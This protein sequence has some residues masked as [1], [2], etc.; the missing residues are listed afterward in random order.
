MMKRILLALVVIIVPL[1]ALAQPDPQNP[2]GDNLTTPSTWKVRL[3]RPNA[4]V[5]IGDQEDSADIWFVNM[6]PGWHITTGPAAIFYHPKSHAEGN[7]RLEATIY[8]FDPGERREAYGVFMGGED[9]DDDNIE[10][11]YFLLRNSE[12]FLLKRRAGNET[13]LIQGWTAHESVAMFGPETESSVQNDLAVEV[14][15]D[16]VVFYV[17]EAEV[18][19][20]PRESVRTEGIVGL[21][22]NHALNVHVSNLSVTPM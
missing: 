20:V 2:E 21:R 5:I 17:N 13:S 19:R 6:T 22:I 7:Y 18:A 4:D 14:N 9:L 12:E 10:Y 11:D 1:I 8:L 15:V 16:E 3:D